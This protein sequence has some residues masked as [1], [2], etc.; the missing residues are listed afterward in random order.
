MGD[1]VAGG[2]QQVAR[3][4]HQWGEV[5]DNEL[6]CLNQVTGDRVV[7]THN[8][9]NHDRHQYHQGDQSDWDGS[10]PASIKISFPPFCIFLN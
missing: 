6:N 2:R 1:R 3:F 4:L 7:V 10:R 8:L 9:V 5:A